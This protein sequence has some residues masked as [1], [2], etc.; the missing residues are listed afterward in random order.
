VLIHTTPAAFAEGACVFAGVAEACA[1]EAEVVEGEAEAAG[2]GFAAAGALEAA[3]DDCGLPEPLDC[4][5]C[6]I[7][8]APLTTNAHAMSRARASFFASRF[9]VLLLAELRAQWNAGS[10]E[11]RHDGEEN[12]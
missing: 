4:G 2:V 10:L 9:I 3:A 1:G 6:A 7:N 8:S 11:F 12:G 5:P